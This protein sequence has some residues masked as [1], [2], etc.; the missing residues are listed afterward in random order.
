M[1]GSGSAG[2]AGKF[3]TKYLRRNFSYILQE[4]FLSSLIYTGIPYN[5]LIVYKKHFAS[6]DCL[7]QLSYT[8]NFY[9]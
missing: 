4:I 6:R 7:V 3:V 1:S 5:L 9:F 2:V 8:G